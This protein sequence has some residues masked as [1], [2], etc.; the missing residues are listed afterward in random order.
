MNK[1]QEKKAKKTQELLEK[2]NKTYRKTIKQSVIKTQK[3]TSER[4]QDF[5][6]K[7]EL[8]NKKRVSLYIDLPNYKKILYI[9]KNHLKQHN[10][11][12]SKSDALN[13]LLNKT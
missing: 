5:G 1:R 6:D 12:I 11:K 2:I 3:T 8:L 4:Q 9:Q 13:I 10:I 7:Q